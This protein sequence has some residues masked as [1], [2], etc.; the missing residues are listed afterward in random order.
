M[1]ARLGKRTA[2][3]GAPQYIRCD[4]GPEFIAA[5][6]QAWAKNNGIE[7]RYIQPGKPSQNGLIERLNK[8]LRIECLNLCWFNSIEEINTELQAWSMT[9]NNLRP[10]QNLNYRAPMSYEKLNDNFYQRLAAA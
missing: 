2:W 3:R 9:Y 4:N 6:L 10:H 7:L 1:V 8:T 5:R